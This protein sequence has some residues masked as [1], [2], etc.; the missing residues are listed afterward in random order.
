[1][2]ARYLPVAGLPVFAIPSRS[3]E[4]D[5]LYHSPLAPLSCLHTPASADNC[6]LFVS[7][8]CSLIS[9]SSADEV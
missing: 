8:H 9:L 7:P 6:A 1:M 2:R 4:I 3:K 5:L